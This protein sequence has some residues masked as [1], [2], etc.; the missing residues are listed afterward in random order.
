MTSS[1][2]IFSIFFPL[3]LG[4]TIYFLHLP[5]QKREIYTMVIVAI[6]SLCV[7]F[8]ITQGRVETVTLY[9]LAG[10]ISIAFKMDALS[11]V[12]ALLLA[13]LWP[14]ATLYAYEYMEHEGREATFFALYTSC[15]GVSLG[16]CFAANL[17]TMYL[18]YEML[19]LIT[20]PL[21]MH[22]RNEYSRPAGI[23]YIAY[24]IS[25]ATAAFAGVMIIYVRAG[26]FSF[27]EGG[28][29]TGIANAGNDVLVQLAFVLMFMGFGVKAAVFPL[30]EWLP[31]VGVAPTPVTAL[32]HAVAVVKSGCFA[33]MRVTYYVFGANV[34]LGSL[35]QKFALLIAAVT[36]AFGSVMA[37]RETHFKR[38]L[39]MST[40]S[41]LS[42]IIYGAVCMTPLGLTAACLHML[43]HGVMKICL[44]FV[45]GATH[46]KGHA[47]YVTELDGYGKRM[48]ITFAAFTVASLA[49]VGVPPFCGFYS[50]LY[51]GYAG[52]QLGT[53]WAYLGIAALL[54][55]AL[56]T[57]L[58]LLDVVVRA[59]FPPKD[60]DYESI[61][62]VTDPT[63]K[64]T[65]PF[66]VLAVLCLVLGLG[67]SYVLKFLSDITTGLF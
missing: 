60:F 6:T 29:L 4:A 17:I 3:I 22:S 31:S 23:K 51:L 18:F 10:A 67:N 58:Y 35:G 15:Y 53:S 33:I 24:S 26:S 16:I 21:I 56:F 40:V 5:K 52:V 11:V 28:I 45:A 54:I 34:L 8:L 41:N 66:I 37:Y 36:I 9:R 2:L 63:W 20:V 49:L 62:H 59:Y 48:P 27:L 7:F 50:K 61:A 13:S 42:Y 46:I 65:V 19:T 47:D 32:L 39:A 57:A 55:S 30:Y 44:F 25:G 38:R 43:Y 12:F 14:I 1:I 64:M